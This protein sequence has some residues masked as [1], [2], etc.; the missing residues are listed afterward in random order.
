MIFIFGI[1]SLAVFFIGL[2]KTIRQNQSFQTTPYLLWMGIF[3]WADAI[4]IA[5]FWIVSSLASFIFEDWILFCLLASLFWVVRALGETVY[6]IQEQFAATHRNEPKSLA[7]EKMFRGELIWVI[8]QLIWQCICV[9][10]VLCSIY[11][12]YLWVSSL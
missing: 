2:Q 9:A 6:W 8:Y 12:G 4:V 10:A 11:F 3:V 7:G 1:L 5:P